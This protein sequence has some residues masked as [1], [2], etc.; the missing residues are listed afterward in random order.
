MTRTALALAGALLATTTFC[1]AANAGGIRLGMAGPLGSFVAHPNLSSGPAGSGGDRHGGGSYE[2]HCD[3]PMHLHGP[4]HAPSAAD[5]DGSKPARHFQVHRVPKPEPQD[6]APKVAKVKPVNTEQEPQVKTAKLE[7]KTTLSDAAPTIVIPDSPVAVVQG[8][9]SSPAS[10]HTAAL[11]PNLSQASGTDGS[12]SKSEPLNTGVVVK[13]VT[14]ETKPAVTEDKGDKT[15]KIEKVE[16]G[17]KSESAGKSGKDKKVSSNTK[18][19]RKF[20][21]AVAGMIS[22][23]CE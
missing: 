17:D 6:D 9:Q 1:T 22:V 14:S 21:P 8:T 11:G 5:D 20:S 3:P 2:R 13:A 18:M 15:E 23:P 19:C 10:V 7:D 16:K 4:R 12:L